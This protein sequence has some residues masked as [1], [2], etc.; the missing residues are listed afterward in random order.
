MTTRALKLFGYSSSDPRGSIFIISTSKIS[1][2]FGGIFPPPA[3]L[4]P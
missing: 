1:T 4:A 2:E 3:P